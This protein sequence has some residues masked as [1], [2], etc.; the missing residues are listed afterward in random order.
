MN[1]CGK[2]FHR[3]KVLDI[4]WRHV[5]IV[6]SKRGKITIY[7]DGTKYTRKNFTIDFWM[8]NQQLENFLSGVVDKDA[9]ENLL[10]TKR[11][12]K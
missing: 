5:A 4:P 2:L 8:K 10:K 6:C 3:E 9:T 12:T 11:R 7:F 1:I